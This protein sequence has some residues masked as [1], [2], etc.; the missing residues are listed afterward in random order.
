MAKTTLTKKKIQGRRKKLNKE[1]IK[2]E[3]KLTSTTLKTLLIIE[4]DYNLSIS[5]TVSPFR[6]ATINLGNT[7]SWLYFKAPSN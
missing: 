2:I 4:K 7:P 3:N 1:D 6:N 5:L